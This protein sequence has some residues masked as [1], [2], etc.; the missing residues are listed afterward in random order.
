MFLLYQISSQGN[1]IFP[2]TDTAGK[3]LPSTTPATPLYPVCSPFITTL[4]L[5]QLCALSTYFS[6]HLTPHPQDSAA[7]LTTSCPTAKPTHLTSCQRWPHPTSAPKP[8]TA[9]S[10]SASHSSDTPT[11][12]P[13]TVA[14]TITTLT[15][16]YWVTVPAALLRQTRTSDLHLLQAPPRAL[17]SSTPPLRL[18]RQTL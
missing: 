9:T 17:L 3:L 4:Y 10:A 16:L 8:S 15:F 5:H 18:P 2:S 7:G 14:Y 6:P 11:A 1:F 13:K 12:P